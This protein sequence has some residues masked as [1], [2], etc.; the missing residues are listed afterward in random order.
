MLRALRLAH[1]FGLVLFVGSIAAFIVVSTLTQDA[2]LTDLAFGRRVISAGTS[3][4]TIPG[5]WLAGLSG[6]WMGYIRFGMRGR[7]VCVKL[8]IMLLIVL[9]AYI[10]VVPAATAAT[11]LAA[12]SVS[13]GRLL[14]GYSRAYLR[15]SIWGGVNVLLSIAAAV[16]GI[17]GMGIRSEFEE[18]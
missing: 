6:A 9:N 5:M 2:S 7:L 11:E 1:L 16:V 17:W 3:V 10:C 4:L 18:R 13:D 14:A 12:R 8:S 15:E